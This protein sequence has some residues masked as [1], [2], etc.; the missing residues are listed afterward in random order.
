MEMESVERDHAVA[1]DTSSTTG[2]ASLRMES[3]C[4]SGAPADITDRKVL[5]EQFRRTRKMEPPAD[6]RRDCLMTST[7]C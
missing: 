6:S 3:W 5:E 1:P 2:S 4:G 7:T